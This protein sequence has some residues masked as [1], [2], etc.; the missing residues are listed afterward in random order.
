[1][2]S[3]P[4][5]AC[6]SSVVTLLSTACEFAP[7]YDAVTV[8]AGGVRLGYCATGSVG[9]E[10]APASTISSE[11]TV[12]KTGLRIKKLTINPVASLLTAEHLLTNE[13]VLRLIQAAR[14]A[15]ALPLIHLKFV[16][17]LQTA[18]HFTYK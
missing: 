14:H 15:R 7:V 16:A 3:A 18:E 10:T 6:S 11:H 8:T 12:A 5:M 17:S 4:L 9:M 2:P 1:M 13:C